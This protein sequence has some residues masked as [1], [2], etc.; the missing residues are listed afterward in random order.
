MALDAKQHSS[1]V[2]VFEPLHT[3]DSFLLSH[4]SSHRAPAVCGEVKG[5]SNGTRALKDIKMIFKQTQNNTE[6]LLEF[7]ENL[8]AAMR[9]AG[10]SLVYCLIE[11]KRC[12]KTQPSLKMAP[13]SAS[14]RRNH[15]A[16]GCTLSVCLLKM[17]KGA[18]RWMKEKSQIAVPSFSKRSFAK[19][20]G[21]NYWNMPPAFRLVLFAK[22]HYKAEEYWI[23]KTYVSPSSLCLVFKFD[24]VLVVNHISDCDLR[25]KSPWWCAVEYEV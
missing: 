20:T 15:V 4:C 2:W 3:A 12:S 23:S 13:F 5:R 17:L 25:N 11:G 18:V 14:A 10:S 16:W 7:W 9:N 21:E 24:N 8:C 1:S 19:R 6:G 22:N